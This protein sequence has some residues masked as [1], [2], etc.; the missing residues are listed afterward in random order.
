LRESVAKGQFREDLYF[1]LA[2]LSLPVPPLRVR[3]ASDIAL[4]AKTF[5]K[6]CDQSGRKSLTESA[7]RVLGEYDW[8]GNVR[9]LRNLIRT[10]VIKSP[11][12]VLD[13]PEVLTEL[14]ITDAL[15]VTS[16]SA[17]SAGFQVQSG[18]GFDGNIERLE[19]FLLE[20]SLSKHKSAEAREVLKLA[21][22]RFYEKAKQYGLLKKTES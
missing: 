20:E 16:T 22:S 19:K 1:R 18:L 17:P 8:P 21:R 4:L 15:E 5:L 9:E 7:F 12:P 3:G 13:A 2:P 14:R 10:L 11:I 6:D